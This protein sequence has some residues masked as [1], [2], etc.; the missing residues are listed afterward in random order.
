MELSTIPTY[1][2]QVSESDI[3]AS[4]EG[5]ITE[6][7]LN[8]LLKKAESNLEANE[9]DFKKQRK[10]YNILVEVLQ[11]LFHHT[12]K[13]PDLKVNGDL[14]KT[15]AFYIAKKDSEY[16]IATANYIM[17][18]NIQPLQAKIDKIN[19]LDKQGLREYY[20][21]VL[22]NGEYSVHGGGGLGM[23]DIARKSGNKLEYKFE[24]IDDEFGVYV[25][26]VK[27]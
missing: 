5:E 27:V 4:Y 11:N 9:D 6:E 10:V 7:I 3:F 23:I 25:L 22:D 8:E 20:K 21:Q 12:D 13:Y 24:T 16:R 14:V 17:T 2:D 15:V 1:K 19:G 26:K 18:Q